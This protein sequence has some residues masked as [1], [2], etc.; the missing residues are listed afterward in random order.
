M[1][2][3]LDTRLWRKK[4]GKQK[5]E[6]KKMRKHLSKYCYAEYCYF[7]QEDCEGKKRI[8]RNEN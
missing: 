5:K 2:N 7:C 6:Q 1:H 8:E 3:M 4:K